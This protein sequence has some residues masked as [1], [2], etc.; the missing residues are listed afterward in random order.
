MSSSGNE[1]ESVRCVVRVRP[2]NQR[3]LDHGFRSILSVLADKQTICLHSKPDEKRFTFDF[4]GD[5]TTTQDEMFARVGKPI[6]ETCLTG[7]NGLIVQSISKSFLFRVLTFFFLPLLSGTIFA[8]GQTGSGKT[9]TIAGTS[10]LEFIDIQ[11]HSIVECFV[12]CLFLTGPSLEDDSSGSNPDRGLLPRVFDFI[13][14]QIAR[15]ALLSSPVTYAVKASYLEIYQ[16]RPYDLLEPDTQNLNI[17]EDAKKGVYVENLHEIPVQNATDAL[18]L[19]V[20]GAQNRRVAATA[21][22]RESSRSHALFCLTI[23]S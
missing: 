17:R 11:S 7:Y 19:A 10:I 8:Y 20:I 3:E 21:M 6:S 13:F 4:C 23:S 15:E 12:F 22:N 16:E 9:H 18:K 1:G 5:A 14:S 2:P